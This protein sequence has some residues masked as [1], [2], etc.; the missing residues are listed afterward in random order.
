[1]QESVNLAKGLE[2]Q[3][4]PSVRTPE[5]VLNALILNLVTTRG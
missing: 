2:Q 3:Y 5:L 1:M 4:S